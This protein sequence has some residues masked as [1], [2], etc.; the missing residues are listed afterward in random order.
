LVFSDRVPLDKNEGVVK[1][2]FAGAVFFTPRVGQR[3]AKDEEL[4]KAHGESLLGGTVPPTI[5]TA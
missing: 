1:R 5:D 3:F 2:H 4:W